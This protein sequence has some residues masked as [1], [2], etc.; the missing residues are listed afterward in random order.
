MRVGDTVRRP[1]GPQSPFVRRLLALLEEK[2][3]GAAPRFEGVDDQG[4]DVLTFHE[5]WV[6]P[7]LEWRRWNDAQLV[8]AAR[9]VR[10]FHDATEGSE[11]TA[12]SAVV[13]HGDLSPC[14][15]VFVKGEPR[16]LIDFDRAHA[17][18]RKSDLAYMAWLWLVGVE[19]ESAPS[20][21]HR[22]G[23]LSL[24]L[25]AYGL[26]DREDFAAA[27][28]AEQREILALAVKP[29][30]IVWVEA[31]LAFVREHAARIDAAAAAHSQTRRR[32]A[33]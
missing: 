29:P 11:L 15:F 17:D 23:Q 18:T 7:N 6:P 5:G 16:Y 3:V 4:R 28:Q 32:R 13:C 27:I 9:I 10:A 33:W 21:E 2:G 8:A 31:E 19:D 1:A 14:N 26:D 30:T 24:L 25:D 12:G 22:I 20:L